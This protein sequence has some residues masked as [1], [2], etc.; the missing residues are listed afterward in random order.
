MDTFYRLKNNSIKDIK[1]ILVW[2][3]NNAE[4]TFI[5][6]LK[7]SIVRVRSDKTFDELLPVI[8]KDN[9]WAFVIILRRNFIAYGTP[10]EQK[11]GNILEIGM[12]DINVDGGEYFFFIYLTEDKL[13]YLKNKYDIIQ[14]N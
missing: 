9:I 13:E 7:D 4:K 14:I 5:D 10:N 2:A 12:R 11:K 8:T 1:D 3:Y 6:V